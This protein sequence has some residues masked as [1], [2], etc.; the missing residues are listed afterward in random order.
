[1]VLLMGELEH[2]CCGEGGKE[3]KEAQRMEGTP[4]LCGEMVCLK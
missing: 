2:V 1:M 3:S 4:G